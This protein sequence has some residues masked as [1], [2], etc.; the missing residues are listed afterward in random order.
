MA[1]HIEPDSKDWTWVLERSCSDCGFDASNFDPSSMGAALRQLAN[2]WDVILTG[3]NVRERINPAVWSALEY[4]CHVRDVIALGRV[5]LGLMLEE[6][7]PLFEN[8]D[9][10]ATAVDFK[11]GLQNPEVVAVELR[12]EAEALANDFD[13]VDGAQWERAGRRSDGASFTVS[14]FARYL[15]HDPVHH[16]WDVR[17]IS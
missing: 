10:D 2:E 3:P 1:N 13:R 5:R 11:Y 12:C 7:D 6:D 4:G 15:I 17:Q 8:W 9:Q 14:S 16:V